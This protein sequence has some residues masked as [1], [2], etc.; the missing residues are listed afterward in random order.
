[1]NR[2]PGP[3]RARAER[4]ELV[5]LTTDA[6]ARRLNGFA[7]PA[8]GTSDGRVFDLLVLANEP[9]GAR[10]LVTT[11]ERVL[12]GDARVA[13]SYRYAPYLLRL[14][15]TGHGYAVASFEPQL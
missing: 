6:L 14:D 15:R 11:R 10:V 7:P 3:G 1:M 9:E 8:S 12:E 5:A 2:S 13:E 4:R